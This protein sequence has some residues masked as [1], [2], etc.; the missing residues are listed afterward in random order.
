VHPRLTILSRFADDSASLEDELAELAAAGAERAGLSARRV[1]RRAAAVVEAS[2]VAVTHLGLGAMFPLDEPA[3]VGAGRAAGQAA[4]DAAAAV[5]ARWVY[6]PT[7]GAPA[8]EWEEAAD[9]FVA[10]VAPVAAYG[11]ERGV[12]LLIEPTIPLFA[13][14]SILTTLCDTVDLAE[15]AGI[16]VCIDVQHCWAERGLRDAI[17]RALPHTG[18]VQISDWIP[19][20][21]SHFRAIPGDGAIPLDRIVGWILEGGYEG[22]FDLEVVP[23]PGVPRAETIARAIDRGGA[24]L[25]RVGL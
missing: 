4:V 20:S 21:R 3:R 10:A 15:R 14:I 22:L 17:R 7:G 19:G 18:L 1:D 25:E 11:R 12:G 8:L 9:A 2:A 16:G 5:G 6:G 24:L 23:E 13:H